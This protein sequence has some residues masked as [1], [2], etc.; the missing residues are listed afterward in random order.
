MIH[1]SES[2]FDADRLNLR[3]YLM[4]RLLNVLADDRIINYAE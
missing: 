2:M 3:K 4:T 1:G